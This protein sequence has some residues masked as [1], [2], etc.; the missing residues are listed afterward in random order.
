MKTLNKM[1]FLSFLQTFIVSIFF[2]VFLIELVDLFADRYGLVS[3]STLEEDLGNPA[4]M[5]QRLCLLLVLEQQITQGI[6]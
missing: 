1:L 6:E 5:A 4:E 3:E 2:F